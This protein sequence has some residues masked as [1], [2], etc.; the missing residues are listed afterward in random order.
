MSLSTTNWQ[1]IKEAL[2]VGQMFFET[3]EPMTCAQWADENFYLSPESSYLEGRWET[4]PF[5]VAILNAMGN[6]DIRV[7]NF[8]KSARVGYTKMILASIGYQLEHKR[9][10]QMLWQ[11]TD[12]GAGDFMKQHVDTMIRDVPVVKALA[13]W[14][15]KKN[16]KNTR[17]TKAFANSRMLWVKGGTSAAN[18]REKSPDIGYYDEL[19]EF[20]RDIE[21]QGSPLFLGDKR[22][23][24][25]PF[26]KSVRGTT[27][28]NKEDSQ[29]E[30]AE[31]ESDAFFRR[32]LPCPCCGEFQYLEFGGPDAEFGLK[33][34]I[35]NGRPVNVRYQCEHCKE[36]F[37]NGSIYEMDIKGEWRSDN[38]IRTKD[39]I[40]FYGVQGEAV[41]TP[42][43]VAF[44]IW[45]AYSP[46]SRGG[47]LLIVRDF[48][49]AKNDPAK[50]KT[51]VNTTKGE[52]WQEDGEVPVDWR[53][54]YLRREQYACPD[55]VVYITAGVDIQDD[56]FEWEVV[57]WGADEQSW[58]LS[59]GVLVGNPSQ[60]VLWDVLAEKL[61]EQWTRDDG[62]ILNTETVCVDSGGHFTDEVYEFSKK[63]GVLWAIPIKGHNVMGRPIATWPAKKS[64]KG[65][66]LVMVGTDN[67]KDLHYQRLKLEWEN[68]ETQEPPPGYCHFP[69]RDEY[70]ERYFKQLTAE[71]KRQRYLAG[72]PVFRW[73]LPGGRRNEALDTRVYALTALR[74][75]QQRKGLR[76]ASLVRSAELEHEEL[77]P[78]TISSG[79]MYSRFQ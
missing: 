43:D 45:T 19:D 28:K 33:W 38:G 24:G 54:L 53:G 49:K 77:R 20:D 32:Y 1:G 41:D 48:L 25:S 12:T 64:K 44:H 34:D 55:S 69:I 56:R 46:F 40:Y 16:P 14:L 50:L 6:D 4:L 72:R 30:A 61:R 70:D 65:V 47:W 26:G 74:C 79:D 66:Y 23:E 60:Q 29:I 76:L 36:C 35:E 52:T 57:G 8:R 21:K 9:R 67:A 2:A 3:P 11:P 22:M 71:V 62:V 58:S 7:V 63:H 42:E 17:D 5:Q 31:E 18:Y 15:G 73:E 37:T 78:V 27:P 68:P 75:A 59:Y 10:N 13:P 39:G 51:W